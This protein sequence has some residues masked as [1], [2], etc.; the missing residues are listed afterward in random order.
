MMKVSE[1][2][3]SSYFKTSIEYIIILA[4]LAVD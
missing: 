1:S 4:Q 3:Y 2:T